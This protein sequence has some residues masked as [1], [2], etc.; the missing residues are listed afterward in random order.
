LN[1][2]T[3][4]EGLGTLVST[5]WLNVTTLP[6]NSLLDCSLNI[7]LL[8]PAPSYAHLICD[9]GVPNGGIWANGQYR[10]VLRAEDD[11]GLEAFSSPK[12]IELRKDTNANFMC[13]LSNADSDWHRCNDLANIFEVQRIYF[14]DDK[15]VVP[16]LGISALYSTASDRAGIR[17]RAWRVYDDAGVL[18]DQFATG[19]NETN[20][21]T[22][23]KA[24]ESTVCLT[25]TDSSNR[26]DTRCYNLSVRIAPP[27]WIEIAPF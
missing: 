12:T 4:P 22:K 19:V 7:P 1:K 9:F 8:P 14:K 25:I 26:S 3:D 2:T 24:R 13:S 18:I 27:D 21:S 20:P 17:N 11:S 6:S 5:E 10:I 16:A 15:N 23:L